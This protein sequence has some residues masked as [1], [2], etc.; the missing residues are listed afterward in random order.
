MFPC[1]QVQFTDPCVKP[2]KQDMLYPQSSQISSSIE[3]INPNT[4]FDF[5]ENSQFQEGVMSKTCQRLDKPFFQEP[6]ELGDLIN[7]GNLIHKYL[8]KQTDIDKILEVMQRKVMKGT[9]LPVEAIYIVHI[10]KTCTYICHKIN[11]LLP[12][13]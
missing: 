3:D 2:I 6:K 7:K 13:W 12:S 11:Y 5:E 9:H 10:S 4:N 1:I 8:P